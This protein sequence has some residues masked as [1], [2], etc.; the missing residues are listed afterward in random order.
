MEKNLPFL[1]HVAIAVKNISEAK[2]IYT[3]L[4]FK[5]EAGE[6]IV[7]SQGVKTA[8]ASIDQNAHLELLEPLENKSGPIHN[9]IAK[10]GGGIHHLCFRV[11]SVEK[12]QKELEALG[13]RFIYSHAVLGA[14]K[15]MV[16]FIHPKNAGGV[17]IEI[18]E[19]RRD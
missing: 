8:F 3:A 17:L 12:K 5:F 4:G 10:T 9:F 16:N 19:K 6:E 15:A 13:Y 14:G 7:E 18:S 11:E 2:K 1:D